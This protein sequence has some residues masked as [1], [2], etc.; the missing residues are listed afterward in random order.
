MEKRTLK[1]NIQTA[2]EQGSGNSILLPENLNRQ[3]LIIM[4][5][6]TD[7]G[8]GIMRTD[9]FSGKKSISRVS[10]MVFLQNIPSQG[11]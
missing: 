9:Q 7:C 4:A 3:V 6:P 10:A 8:H 2:G 11:K 5:V 1:V